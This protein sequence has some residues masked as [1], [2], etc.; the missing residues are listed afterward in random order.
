M[1]IN[2]DST[3]HTT[4]FVS[5]PEACAMLG[6]RRETLYAYA[7]RGLVRSY[8]SAGKGR[9]RMYLRDDI[10]RLKARHDARSGHGP[11]AAGALRWGEPV[12]DSSITEMTVDG[13]RYRGMLATDLVARGASFEQVAELLWSG[14][15]VLPPTSPHWPTAAIPEAELAPLAA[16]TRRPLAR[17]PLLLAAWQAHSSFGRS[18]RGASPPSAEATR[19]LARSLIAALPWIVNPAR[20]PDA[21]PRTARV[22]ERI[23][24]LLNRSAQPARVR[25]IDAALV[26][27]A[28]HE[29]TVSS[30]AARVVA[31]SGADLYAVLLAAASAFSGPLHGTASEAVEALVE[32]IPQPHR[33][34]RMAAGYA[35]RGEAI[36]GF[37][38][39]LYRQ[40]DPRGRV[41]LDL[42]TEAAGDKR[43]LRIL[44]ALVEAAEPLGQHPSVDVA[45]V[46]AAYALGAPKGTASTLFALGRAAGLVAHALEQRESGVLIRPRARY[47]SPG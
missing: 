28:D 10:L 23:C 17:M 41:L 16:R 38:H 18:R 4:Q 26:L 5:S 20:W 13:P 21:A 25:L 9:G 31:S 12:L 3:I 37:G 40:G 45:L 2:V 44:N 8:P 24:L 47:I 29:L 1:L 14:G 19:R 36:P 15:G 39:H 27:C 46:A 32:D 7:S 35:M 22:A 34:K 30:F 6:I 42:S 33:A 11:V 43:E